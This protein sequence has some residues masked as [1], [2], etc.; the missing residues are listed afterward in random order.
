MLTLSDVEKIAH[1]AR[2]EL[3]QAEKEK[4]LGQLSAVLE[5]VAA[6]DEVDVSQVEPTTHA[7]PQHNVLRQDKVEPGLSLPDVLFNAPQ[8]TQ[9]QFFIQAILDE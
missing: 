9:N 1:L 7:V 6:L 2:L 5:A 8:Q 4:Y 3:T